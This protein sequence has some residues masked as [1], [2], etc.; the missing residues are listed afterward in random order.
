MDLNG[1]WLQSIGNF[2]KFIEV[3]SESFKS[4]ILIEWQFH[5]LVSEFC[6]ATWH[7]N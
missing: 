4:I 3:S 2:L 6:S 1:F 7:L 5:H